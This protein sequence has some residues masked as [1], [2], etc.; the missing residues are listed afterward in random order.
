MLT[1]IKAETNVNDYIQ[2]AEYMESYETGLDE[3]ERNNLI[4]LVEKQVF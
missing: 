1:D 3:R 4:W 2:A